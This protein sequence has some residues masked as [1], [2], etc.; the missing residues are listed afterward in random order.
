MSSFISELEKDI[1]TMQRIWWKTRALRSPPWCPCQQSAVQ[2]VAWPVIRGEW[3][4]KLPKIKRICLLT[5]AGCE[6]GSK[7]AD[8]CRW[9]VFQDIC[10]YQEDFE[11]NV[12]GRQ[13]DWK[14]IRCGAHCRILPF[15][16]TV[17]QSMQSKQ[18]VSVRQARLNQEDSTWEDS[19]KRNSASSDSATSGHCRISCAKIRILRPAVSRIDS[20]RSGPGCKED[21]VVLFPPLLNQVT[22]GWWTTTLFIF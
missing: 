11:D 17:L 3:R 6:Q 7:A 5:T 2:V 9:I 15:C 20:R 18:D 4:V 21:D 14:T 8:R 12:I 19:I 13:C 22:V 16:P 1:L 10:L